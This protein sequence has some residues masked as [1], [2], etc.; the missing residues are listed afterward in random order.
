MNLY[1][2]LETDI[3]ITAAQRPENSILNTAERKAA[4]TAPEEV[5]LDVDKMAEGHPYYS[6]A[7][8]SISPDNTK[9][10]YGVDD[11]SRRQYKLF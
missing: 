5:L 9:M 8:F 11:V 1:L 3:T 7:G 10:I 6:A 2:F 4:F